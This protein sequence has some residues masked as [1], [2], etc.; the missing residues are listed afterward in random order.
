MLA[1]DEGHGCIMSLL[2]SANWSES[3][4]FIMIC[5]SSVLYSLLSKKLMITSVN[6]IGLNWQHEL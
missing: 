4:K 5:D 2:I 1:L 3:I 6:E